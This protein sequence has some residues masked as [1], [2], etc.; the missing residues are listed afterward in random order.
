MLYDMIPDKVEEYIFL[1]YL[2]RLFERCYGGEGYWTFV[3]TLYPRLYYAKGETE[4]SFDN[5]P[6]SYIYSFIKNLVLYGSVHCNHFPHY[7]SLVT[8][9]YVY[10]TDDD[11]SSKL[12]NSEDVDSEYEREYGI[13]DPVGWIYEFDVESV[14]ND[15][16]RY[17]ELLKCLEDKNFTLIEEFAEMREYLEKLQD[18]QAPSGD[19]L[20]DLFN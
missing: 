2:T 9:E 7:D 20:F 3:E 15:T 8:A 10:V 14:R 11:G 16:N 13:P 12:V 18:K 17:A 1:P 4:G 5:D 6:E 19:S